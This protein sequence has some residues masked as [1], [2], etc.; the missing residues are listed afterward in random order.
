MEVLWPDGHSS[1]EEIEIDPTDD[2]SVQNS[3][4]TKLK[5]YWGNRPKNRIPK[6]SRKERQ[7]EWDKLRVEEDI[8]P[9]A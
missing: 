3:I 5:E 4:K 9:D 8:F 7:E 1:H 2:L 6:P